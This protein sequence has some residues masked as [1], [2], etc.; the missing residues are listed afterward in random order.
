MFVQSS[1]LP[2]SLL[3]SFQPYVYLAPNNMKLTNRLSRKSAITN[4]ENHH[5]I[6]HNIRRWALRAFKI[7]PYRR[8]HKWSYKLIEQLFWRTLPFLFGVLN[9]LRFTGLYILNKC[10]LEAAWPNKKKTANKTLFSTRSLF[11]APLEEEYEAFNCHYF[12]ILACA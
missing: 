11:N 1:I 2:C 12:W 8:F 5:A 4:A 10:I 9:R 7:F 3:L 6:A